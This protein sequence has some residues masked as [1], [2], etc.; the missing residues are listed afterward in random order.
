MKISWFSAGVSSAV[1]TKMANPDLIIYIDIED[2]HPDTYRF[3]KDCELWFGKK[4]EVLKSPYRTVENVCVGQGFIKGHSG[5]APCTGILKKRVRKE[6]EYNNPG[7]HTYVWG[8]DG[9]EK[10]RAS[11][12]VKASPDFD[13]DFPILDRTKAEVHGMLE[14]AGIKRPAMY[15]MGYPNNNCI[16]CL[17]GGMGYWN[18]IRRDFPEVFA[19]RSAMER[20]I[21]AHILKECYLDELDINRGR[22]L[23][24]IVPDCGIF[25]EIESQNQDARSETKETGEHLTTAKAQ[26]LQSQ[27]SAV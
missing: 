21:G 26:N 8:F 5:G 1:A 17:R 7:R 6:W 24:V 4:I 3:I 16:G 20:K 27:T 23:E 13:H 22:K 19:K 14:T 12:I 10:D 11:R 25:C 18:K 2:Q 15:D 9:N